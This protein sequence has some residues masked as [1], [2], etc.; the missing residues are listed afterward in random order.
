MSV[1]EFERRLA[2]EM[3]GGA[4]SPERTAGL[5]ARVLTGLQVEPSMID[6]IRTARATG[7]RT[8]LLSNSWGL[9]YVRDGWETRLRRGGDLRG[10][11][12]LRKPDPEI[13]ALAAERLRLPPE[14][15][16]IVDDLAPRRWTSWRS[17]SGRACADQ[18]APVVSVP[19]DRP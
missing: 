15:I 2:A 13:Y 11:V 5:L 12:G 6:V 16:L 19:V 9:D 14:Q 18:H 7:F 1:A 3:A 10:G 17:C 4:A 8:G